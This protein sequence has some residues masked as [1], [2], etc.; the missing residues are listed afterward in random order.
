MPHVFSPIQNHI[1]SKLKNAKL[2]RCSE[3]QPVGQNLL[4]M[5]AHQKNLV[6]F[7]VVDVIEICLGGYVGVGPL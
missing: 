4:R 5:K 2:L 7:F 3:L 1:L 6:R